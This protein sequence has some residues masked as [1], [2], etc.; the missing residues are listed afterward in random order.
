MID[1]LKDWSDR[2]Y[3]L[4]LV[5]IN[6]ALR[7]SDIIKLRVSNFR[8]WYIVVVEQKT[9]KYKKLKMNSFLKKEIERFCKGKKNN[10][11]LFQSRNGI[12]KPITRQM[13]YLIL[14]IAANDCGIENV[15]THTMRKTFGYHHYQKYKDIGVLMNIFNHSSPAITQ[16]Y[17]GINQD[18][19]DAA[20]DNFRLG[21]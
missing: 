2:N 17:I 5:G 4:F 3:M 18:Y 9:K 16:K 21:F 12:N 11:Y 14:R 13:A 10:E 19:I 8:G 20:M 6:T 1:Y 15:G 7:I